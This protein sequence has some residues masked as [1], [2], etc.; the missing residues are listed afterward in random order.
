M[1]FAPVAFAV[2]SASV[3]GSPATAA[4]NVVASIKPVHALVSAVMQGVAPPHLIVRGG[5]TPHT[6]SLR[7]SDAEALSNADLVFWIGPDLENFLDGTIETLAPNARSID[8][9]EAPEMALLPLRGD[10]N[11]EHHDH[12]NEA[13]LHGDDSDEIDMHLWLDPVNAVAIVQTAAQALVTIDPENADLYRTNASETI[14]R[15]HDLQAQIDADLAPFRDT[16]FVTFHDAYQYFERRFGVPAAGAITLNPES[17]SGARRI[18][19]VRETITRLGAVCIFTEPQF[20][21]ALVAIAAEGSN[22]R[23]GTLDPIGADLQ[24][25]PDLYFNLMR[26]MADNMRACLAP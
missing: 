26:Q 14:A 5:A 22:A 20:E 24:D 6:F 7:P 12:D 8:L 4:P 18:A 10:A 1:R 25:G 9:I 2:L 15:L 11:F 17:Q 21:P 19:E 3:F 13:D 23:T 16:P